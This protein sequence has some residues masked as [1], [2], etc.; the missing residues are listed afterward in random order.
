[1]N[2]AYHS[3]NVFIYTSFV[4]VVKKYYIILILNSIGSPS[5]S[6]TNPIREASKFATLFIIHLTFTQKHYKQFGSN[7]V[8]LTLTFHQ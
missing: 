6:L 2:Q 7:I 5:S 1:M 3:K 8:T 4:Y